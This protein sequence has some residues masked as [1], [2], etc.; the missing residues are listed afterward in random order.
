MPDDR[1]GSGRRTHTRRG[2][3]R[4]ETRNLLYKLSIEE[5]RRVGVEKARIRD[6][7]EAAGVVP[8]TFYFHFPT[9][10]H[11][12]FELAQRNCERAAELLPRPSSRPL[13]PEAFLR[14]LGDALLDAEDEL[15]DPELGRAALT[16]FLRPPAGVDWSDNP[17]QQAVLEF[18]EDAIARGAVKS[19]LG[20]QEIARILLLSVFG[21][22]LV[23]TATP[24]DRRRDM[25]RTLAF[26][27]EALR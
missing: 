20:A 19:R 1:A 21:T 3:Q 6:I 27:I 7:V 25:R 17:V 8:G 2:Q 23:P 9:K 22:A 14:G 10:D 11:V 4:L 18:L 16:I 13:S 5:F 24:E 12:L 26:F 15:A